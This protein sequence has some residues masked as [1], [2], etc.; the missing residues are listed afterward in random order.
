MLTFFEFCQRFNKPD[1]LRTDTL[2]FTISE[3]REI[4]RDIEEI[5]R[6]IEEINCEHSDELEDD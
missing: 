4:K 1:Q 6:D 5:K 3:L 2:T